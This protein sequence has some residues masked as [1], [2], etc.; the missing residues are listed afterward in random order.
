MMPEPRNWPRPVPRFG[1]E[2]SITVGQPLTATIQPLVDEW[3]EL[4]KAQRGKVGI[5]GDWQEQQ[6]SPSGSHQRAVR[7]AGDLADGREREMRIRICDALQAGV[8]ALGEQVERDE[9]RFDRSE[10]TNSRPREA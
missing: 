4:A 5:G 10:W 9:G 2:V 7:A 3:R 6:Q 1:G 8:G